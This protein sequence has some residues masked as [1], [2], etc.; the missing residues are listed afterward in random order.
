MKSLTLTS[1][2][3]L[4]LY[5][6][7]LGKLP[8]KYHSILTL[9]E[10][11]S[12]SDQINLKPLP[13]K[14]IRIIVSGGRLGLCTNRQNLAYQAA[15]LL[16]RNFG[17]RQGVE[18]RIRK[19][20]P[21]AAGLGGGSSNA[22]AVLKGLNRLWKLNLGIERL[23]S[24][25]RKIGSDVPFF[26]YNCSFACG[27]GRGDKIKVLNL[28]VGFW[29][30]I[31]VPRIKVLS[32]L[33]Y[34]KWDDLRKG[35]PGLRKERAGLTTL[36]SKVKI[37][38]TALLKKDTLLLEGLLFNSLESITA[39]MHPAVRKIKSALSDYG[40]KE[41]SMSGSGPAVFGLVSSRKEAYAVAGQLSNFVSWD[42]FVAKTV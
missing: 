15:G 36:Q 21:V 14:K 19:R 9:F 2:A 8:D 3:K 6:D 20:I 18:I 10:R 13:D 1:Y 12:L 35:R 33:V 5:L 23:V 27:S 22:A 41:I 39:A 30:I 31:A 38:Q 24:V 40:V 16:A 4:N 17:I 11:I 34:K 37:L 7:I 42:V 29:H 28:P 26:L 32:S 25:G